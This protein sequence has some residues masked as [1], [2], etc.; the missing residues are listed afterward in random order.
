MGEGYIK[1]YMYLIPNLLR[2]M[3]QLTS[4]LYEIKY[5][6]IHFVKHQNYNMYRIMTNDF[7]TEKKK[8][9]YIEDETTTT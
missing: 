3:G 6:I 9:E 8:S 1:R 2:E 4:L 7:R 5:N